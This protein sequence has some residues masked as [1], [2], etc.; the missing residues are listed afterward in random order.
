[1]PRIVAAAPRCLQD[2]LHE[3]NVRLLRELVPWLQL[4]EPGISHILLQLSNSCNTREHYLTS[5]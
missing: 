2:A 4:H 3:D 1:M 5:F